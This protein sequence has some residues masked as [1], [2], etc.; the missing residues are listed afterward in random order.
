MRK[1]TWNILKADGTLRRRLAA[2][3]GITDITAAILANRG[4]TDPAA[5]SD[6]LNADMADLND[7]FMLKDMDRAV[8]KIGRAV[9]RGEK[10][11]V[12]GDYDVDGITAVALLSMV[13]K[14]IGANAVTYIPHRVEEG[15]GLNRS[16][17]KQAHRKGVSLL[18]TVDC[19]ISGG[20][21][22]DYLK[23]LGI[24]TIVTDHH[25]IIEGAFPN[26]AYAVINPLQRGCGYPFKGLAGVGLA[27]KLAEALTAGCGYDVTSHLDL[28]ALGTIQ[29]MVPQTGE[30]RIFV[31]YGLALMERGSNPGISALIKASG[32]SKRPISFREVAYMLGPRINAAG[33]I[34]SADLALRLLV[35]DDPLRADELAS[36]LNTENRNRQKIEGTILREAMQKVENEI[37]FKNDMVIVLDGDNWHPGVIGIV[38]SRVAERFNRPTI[39]ISFEADLGRGSGRSISNFH[40]FDA[41]TECRDLLTDF[42]GHASA[43]GIRITRKMLPDFR[44]RL[45]GLVSGALEMDELVPTIDVDAVIPLHKIDERLIGELDRLSPFGPG[46]PRPVLSSTG[47]TLKS[48]PKSIRRDGIKMWVTDGKITCEAVGFG[49]TH[50]LEDIIGADR[51]DMAYTPGLNRWRGLN[52]LQLELVDMRAEAFADKKRRHALVS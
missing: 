10:I 28:V 20:K 39:M 6:F 49:M 33:R 40:L 25:K 26:A 51:V 17:V 42:G 12:Y 9:S 23:S 38:A 19:G 52:T 1:K 2:E 44:R 14:G 5:A 18:I 48:R 37:N 29:D 46:N 32:I 3:C 41:L 4:I 34:G 30:N 11:M 36:R 31:K 7:P 43:C 13:L 47:L 15:Y 24:S 35:C 8:Q 21:E 45:N 50:L 27:Y 16:A 22:V